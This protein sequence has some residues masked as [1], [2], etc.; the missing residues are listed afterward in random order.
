MVEEFANA[1]REVQKQGLGSVSGLVYT[2]YGA[3]I[4]MF[5]GV[6]ENVSITGENTTLQDL[7]NVKL[8]SSSDKNMLDLFIEKVTKNDYST[9]QTM[10]IEQLREN[11]D[12]V[13]NK[14]KLKDYYKNS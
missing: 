4:I 7:A 10:I 1:S 5:T 14:T 8:K 9:Q 2:E 6:P 3:H 13:I 11:M 12:I